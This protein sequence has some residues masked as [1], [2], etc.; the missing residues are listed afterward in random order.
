MHG[1]AMADLG[2]LL[3]RLDRLRTPI[4]V[5]PV[6]RTMIESMAAALPLPAR[7]V[8][9]RLLS[10]RWTDRTLSRLGET[11]RNLEPLFRNTVNATVVRG[12]EKPNVIPSEISVGL[13]ARLLPGYTLDDLLAELR[14][15]LGRAPEIDVRLYDPGPGEADLGML[16]LLAG[17]LREAE[18]D[19]VPIPYLLPGSSDARFF[20]RLGIQTYGFTPMDLPAEFNF[21]DTIHAADERIPIEAVNFGADVLYRL[22]ARYD[23]APRGTG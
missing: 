20:S 11:G 7:F 3:V 21:F 22:I 6:V 17:L 10:P 8:L 4:H 2:R 14:P 15:S 18:P 12:G 5:T 9:R 16:D 19:A 23:G 13:D 1:G